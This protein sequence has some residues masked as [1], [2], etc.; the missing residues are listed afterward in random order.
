MPTPRRSCW[1]PPIPASPTAPRWPGPTRPVVR[2][3]WPERWWCSCDG[4]ACAWLDRRG[5]TL[6][7]FP[8]AG[9]V[10][11]GVA[12]RPRRP[13]EGRPGPQPGG[14]QDRRGAGRQRRPGRG[15]CGRSGSPTGTGGWC[16]GARPAALAASDDDRRPS[17]PILG[18]M[19]E[20]D[21]IHRTAAALRTAVL[22]KSLTAFEAPRLVGMRPSIGAVIERVESKGKHLE[23]GFD[24]GVV[25][26]THMRMSGSWHLYRAG[27]AVAQERPPGPGHHRGAG[28]AGG[29]LLGAGRAHL[30]GQGVPA[31][32]PARPTSDPTCASPTPT[33]TSAWPA[34]TAWSSPRPRW[35]RCCSTSGSPPASGTSTSPRCSGSA[36][37]TPSPRSVPCSPSSDS[38]CWPRPVACCAPTSTGRT[39]SRCPASPAVWPS[40]AAMPSRVPAAARPSRS[41]STASRPASPTGARGASCSC[42]WRPRRT[43]R[44]SSTPSTPTRTRTGTAT[45]PRP[46]VTTR[47]RAVV[48]GRAGA[49]RRAR[50]LVGRPRRYRRPPRR[51]RAAPG[52]PARP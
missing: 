17:R 24:D 39:G 12:R 29:V 38:R 25:L 41:P 6:L 32:P 49:A 36:S 15:R 21:T 18:A 11:D 22:G 47:R 45:G 16:F 33:S 46:V 27:R 50:G 31:E 14:A 34:S 2:R 52:A 26:H 42:P 51:G 10:D 7:T 5:H 19:P 28:L 40:T 1:P 30:P 23:I 4:E 9:G 35:P 13:R 37:C 44:A 20:G 8:A 43:R 3:G 48:A